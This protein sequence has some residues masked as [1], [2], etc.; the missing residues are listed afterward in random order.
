MTRLW[1]YGVLVASVAKGNQNTAL[2]AKRTRSLNAITTRHSPVHGRRLPNF[3]SRSAVCRLVRLSV[4]M[5]PCHQRRQC[6]LRAVPIITDSRELLTSRILSTTTPIPP[7]AS[8]TR[9]ATSPWQHIFSRNRLCQVSGMLEW[10]G[11]HGG[12]AGDNATVGVTL[13]QF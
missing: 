12:E 1:P 9:S 13:M 6:R 4:C 11:V 10:T 2:R 8:D 3:T 7:P 5:S